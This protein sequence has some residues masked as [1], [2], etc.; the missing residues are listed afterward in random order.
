M[1]TILPSS[2]TI[3]NADRIIVLDDGKVVGEG[4]HRELMKS[5]AV[6]ADIARSQLSEEELK[7]E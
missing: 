5:C 6:Y 7:N 2:S 3:M 1:P 4:T